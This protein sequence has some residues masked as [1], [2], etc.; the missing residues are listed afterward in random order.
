MKIKFGRKRYGED[1][2]TMGDW[3]TI[4]T[5]FIIDLRV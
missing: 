4:N 2:N 3:M 1:N 5:K